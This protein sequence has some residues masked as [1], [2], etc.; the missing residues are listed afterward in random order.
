MLNEVKVTVKMRQQPPRGPN[1]QSVTNRLLVMMRFP[2]AGLLL[3][4]LVWTVVGS[5]PTG[6]LAAFRSNQDVMIMMSTY[7]L[8][9]TFY[10]MFHDMIDPR[11]WTD[12]S[13]QCNH[14]QKREI[15][16]ETRP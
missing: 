11:L 3:V 13:T 1:F 10:N 12:D 4:P 16:Q 2:L 15:R 7:N 8:I 5:N 9:L 14:K 6:R